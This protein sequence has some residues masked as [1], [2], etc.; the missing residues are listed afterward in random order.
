VAVLREYHVQESEAMKS[1]PDFSKIVQGIM[2]TFFRE[3]FHG[4]LSPATPA[5]GLATVIGLSGLA[6]LGRFL[7]PFLFFQSF[8]VQVLLGSPLAPGH[9]P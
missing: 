9:M 2:R 8:H 5:H 4:S 6:H 1:L 3:L 7:L